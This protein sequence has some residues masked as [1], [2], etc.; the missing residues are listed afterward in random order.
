MFLTYLT[1]GY[2][3]LEAISSFSKASRENKFGRYAWVFLSLDFSFN[4]VSL[5]RVLLA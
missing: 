3:Y 2:L 5:I 1:G 4:E